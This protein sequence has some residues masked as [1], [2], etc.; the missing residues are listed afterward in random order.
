MIHEALRPLFALRLADRSHHRHESLLER[1]FRKQPP[2]QIR[3]PER[4]VKRVS[5]NGRA[6]ESGDQHVAHDARNAGDE[7]KKRNRG[8]GSE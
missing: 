7:R 8:S 5:L 2:E 4:H 1:S 3:E 6:E